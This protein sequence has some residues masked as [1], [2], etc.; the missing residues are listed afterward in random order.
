MTRRS[1]L[2]EKVSIIVPV[3]PFE[4]RELLVRSAEAID[5]LEVPEGLDREVFYVMDAREG[6]KD[7]RASYFREKAPE[8]FNLIV[9]NHS[10][11]RRAGAISRAL[12]E[13]DSPR[14]V[15][16]FD[17]DSRP[18]SNFI[19]SGIR[20][21]KENEDAFMSTPV[22]DIIN[23]DRN[24]VTRT[25]GAE[26]DFLSSMQNLIERTR[27]FNH[28]NGLIAVHDGEYLVEKGLNW[29]R[30]CEDTDYTERAY[31]DGKRPV[32]NNASSVGEQAMTSWQDL[33]SQ[34]V[35][36]MRGGLE[37]LVHYFGPFM[38]SDIP[39][40]IKI[41]WMSAVTLPFFAFLLSPLSF[42]YGSWILLRERDLL[43][44]VEDSVLLFF[45]AWVV[46]FCGIVNI[47]KVLSSKETA[48]SSSEREIV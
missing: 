2:E 29:E 14:Y 11:G 36:W 12:D 18:S 41:S 46:S 4:P 28:F 38:K 16:I 15:T 5:Q 21:L 47:Y 8:A 40:R 44:A 48:W 19:S 30:T 20:Q 24:V 22:R 9:R 10:E 7:D 17:I 32:L 1:S 33:Y 43:R 27:G 25:V 3:A 39:L 31:L 26:Y 34:K 23:R 13:A 6:P 42:L 35:R 45:F 37:G